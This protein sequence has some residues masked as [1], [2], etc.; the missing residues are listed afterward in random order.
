MSI[1]GEVTGAEDAPVADAAVSLVDT[2]TGYAY[3]N[4]VATRNDGSYTLDGISPG[5]YYLLVKRAGYLP[6]RNK[7]ATIITDDTEYFVDLDISSFLG[8]VN[9]DGQRNVSDLTD[10]LSRYG[11]PLSAAPGGLTPT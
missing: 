4:T 9:N 5:S 8:D 2:T 3:A 11:L 10:L 7:N 6:A 1:H